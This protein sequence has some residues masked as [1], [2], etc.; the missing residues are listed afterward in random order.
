[1]NISLIRKVLSLLVVS[2]F[3]NSAPVMAADELSI[4]VVDVQELLTQ[5]KAARSIQEQVKAEREKFLAK[6][7]KEEEVLRGMEKDFVENAKDLTPEQRAEKKKAFEEKFAATQKKAQEGK[8]KIEKAVVEAMATLNKEA[9]QAV[10]SVAEAAGYNLILAKQHVVASD[11]SID[12]SEAS[13]KKLN[14]NIKKI[15]LKVAN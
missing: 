6:I 2:A 8:G 3:L 12:I 13:M 1:M 14:D 4:A 9:F 11:K 7:S 10:E 5:S 15:D